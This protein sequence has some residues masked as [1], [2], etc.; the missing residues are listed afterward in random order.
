MNPYPHYISVDF[1]LLV[2]ACFAGLMFR[3]STNFLELR[4]AFA[5]T[6]LLGLCGDSLLLMTSGRPLDNVFTVPRL[7][8]VVHRYATVAVTLFWG[9]YH[10]AR[11]WTRRARSGSAPPPPSQSS[12]STM[13]MAL[14]LLASVPLFLDILNYGVNFVFGTSEVT[15]GYYARQ[16][17]KQATEYLRVLGKAIAFPTAVVAGVAWQQ[18]RRSIYWLAPALLSIPLVAYF[19]RGMFL[20]FALFFLGGSFFLPRRKQYKYLLATTLFTVASFLTGMAMRHYAAKTGLAQYSELLES[21]DLE[22]TPVGSGVSQPFRS[23]VDATSSLGV[24]TKVFEVGP[25]AE[26]N[27]LVGYVLLQMPIPSF[28]LPRSVPKTNLF[29]DLHLHGAHFP[30]PLLG[31]MRVF[32]G[33]AGTFIYFLFGLAIGRVDQAINDRDLLRARPYLVAIFYALA[34]FLIIRQ[35]HSGL[36]SSLRPTMYFTAAWLAWRQLQRPA[37]TVE[38]PRNPLIDA[39]KAL[40]SRRAES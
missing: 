24:A 29:D 8:P 40:P 14:L 20:P 39:V 25:R 4:Y 26:G 7:I 6:F 1:Y 15:R 33:W 18:H 27:K 35:F 30:Y 38:A 22:R 19:S 12:Q 13:V 31:E 9:G 37:H 36:R 10:L 16:E 28:M 21:S 5:A 34:L 32:F 2:F 3:P 23:L 11:W 17:N